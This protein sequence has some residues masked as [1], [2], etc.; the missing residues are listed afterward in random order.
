MRQVKQMTWAYVST[1]AG[2]REVGLNSDQFR[3]WVQAGALVDDNG[4][5]WIKTAKPVE[6]WKL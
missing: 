6:G 4:Q 3:R 1:A 2:C 5:V